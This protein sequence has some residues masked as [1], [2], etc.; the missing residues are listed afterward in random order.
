MTTWS[1]EPFLEPE[2]EPGSSAKARAVP[3]TAAATATR[4]HLARAPFQTDML[5]AGITLI[6]FPSRIYSGPSPSRRRWA[7]W[8]ESSAQIS[9]V[10]CPSS[11]SARVQGGDEYDLQDLVES[12]LRFLYNDVRP[13]ERTPS[14]AGS[15]SVMDFLL[16]DAE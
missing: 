5:A 9:A 7:A 11:R 2:F 4:T 15:S 10:G 12:L 6:M 13:E 3:T 8:Y 1:R 16:R 14:Y